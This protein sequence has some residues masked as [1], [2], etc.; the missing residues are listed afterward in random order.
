VSWRKGAYIGTGLWVFYV[1]LIIQ[2][3]I[4]GPLFGIVGIVLFAVA[5][6]IDESPETGYVE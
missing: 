5:Y 4:I 2:E 1:M 3:T 6:A